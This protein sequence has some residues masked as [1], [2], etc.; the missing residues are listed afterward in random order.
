MF[1]SLCQI[2]RY[3][4]D[5]T[6]NIKE[7]MKK[8][9]KVVKKA[10]VKKV[11]EPKAAKLKASGDSFQDQVKAVLSHL[12]ELFKASLLD[13]FRQYVCSTTMAGHTASVED[14][15]EI[16]ENTVKA[17]NISKETLLKAL[18]EVELEAM[19]RGA[20]KAAIKGIEPDKTQ[21]AKAVQASGVVSTPVKE[22]K[23][24][25]DSLD[26]IEL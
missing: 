23:S 11:K 4:S 8:K 9:T 6:L 7:Y 3:K 20:G 15:M 14:F 13:A 12:L 2:R 5:L 24:V 22:S 10:A 25:F 17:H 21:V 26:S 19:A 16:H 18:S 1:S